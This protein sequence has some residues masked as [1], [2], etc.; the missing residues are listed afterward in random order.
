LS[1]GCR[2]FSLQT[3]EEDRAVEL[4]E[5]VGE[6]LDWPVHTWSA[7]SGVDGDRR[8]PPL[9][10][11][12]ARLHHSIDDALWVVL[13][14]IAALEGP[15]A[16]RA[17]RELSQRD[18]GPAVVLVDPGVT[19]GATTLAERVPELEIL[20]LPPP[21]QSE[22][23]ERLRW[24]ASVLETSG[25]RGAEDRLHLAASGLARASVGLPRRAFDRL[26]AEAVLEHGPDPMAIERFI[27]HAKPTALDR[28]GLLNAVRPT[29]PDEL[30]GLALFKTW[31]QRRALALDPRAPEAGICDPRGVL[32]LGVQGCGKSLAARVCASVLGVPLVR[33]EPGRLFGGTVGESEANLRR[34]TEAA[35]GIAPAVLWLDEIDKGLVGTDGASSDAGTAARVL[36]GL[37]TWLQERTRPVFVV[38]TANRVDTLPPELLRRGRLD[39]I[40]FV[41]LPDA[42]DR[43]AIL[44]VH[45]HTVPAR[46]SSTPPSLGDPWPA[47]AEIVHH[48][49]GFSGAEIESALIE[50]R[51]AAFA[52][53][54]D[55]CASDLATAIASMVPLSVT[56]AESIHALRRWAETRAR[57]A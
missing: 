2:G 47:F 5:R 36:G 7:A 34:A 18:R 37:L 20:S 14:G 11:L 29:A 56:R 55:L 10:E 57:P 33:L 1:A 15:A 24:I 42:H 35:E 40:F 21:G 8:G 50:A 4:L 31:L 39:E 43:E 26:V 13:D 38:A 49:E 16:V 45:L 54:R 3:V 32:L 44:R 27:T 19:F 23:A 22:L 46:R 48:A 25:Y 30:G 53:Q 6:S 28:T 51:L 12:F 52:E 41:D 17:L 9:S